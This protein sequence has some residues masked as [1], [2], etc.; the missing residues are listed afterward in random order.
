MLT[1]VT[2]AS[3]STSSGSQASLYS[4]RLLTPPLV[5]AFAI[6]V[7]LSDQYTIQTEILYCVA[8]IHVGY[9][10]P[11]TV[12]QFRSDSWLHS[13]NMRVSAPGDAFL[14]CQ[15]PRTF[16]GLRHLVS[17]DGAVRRAMR[18]AFFLSWYPRNSSTKTVLDSRL[19]ASLG[20]MA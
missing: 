17:Y 16:S 5:T 7:S 13:L 1:S 9:T 10:P 14:R 20:A 15:N 18:S 19:S 6:T 3:L 12:C 2:S 4:L 11:G 8:R